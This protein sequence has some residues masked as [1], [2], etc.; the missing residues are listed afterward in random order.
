MCSGEAAALELLEGRNPLAMAHYANHP[1]P[2]E[3]PNAGIAS[4]TFRPVG[5]SHE[6]GSQ[7]TQQ[8]QQL[9]AFPA[10]QL[11]HGS[12]TS[13]SRSS[14]APDDYATGGSSSSSSGGSGSG[15]QLQKAVEQEPWVRAYVPNVNYTL[16]C[17]EKHLLTHVSVGKTLGMVCFEV[18]MGALIT[19]HATKGGGPYTSDALSVH[20]S[21]PLPPRAV[22]SE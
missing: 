14:S 21:Q 16:K 13:G 2:G 17:D 7:R 18:R 20:P 22:Q 6:G 3:R 4:F 1:P 12:K 19:L 8:Q 5:C 10:G 15:V 9:G 11:Q